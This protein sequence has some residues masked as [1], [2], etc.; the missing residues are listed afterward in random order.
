[1]FRSVGSSV[2]CW[3]VMHQNGWGWK[4]TSGRPLAQPCSS[5]ETQ[6]RVPWQ[7][8]KISKEE[9]WQSLWVTCASALLPSQH[10]SVFLSNGVSCAHF[11]HLFLVL[12]TTGKKKK[13]TNP[14][15]IL[16]AHI[17]QVFVEIN[18]IT[19]SLLFYKLSSSSSL[20]LAS[21]ERSSSPF[22][23]FIGPM[24][25]FLG[26]P[27][28]SCTGETWTE[29]S[30]PGVASSLLSRGE[31]SLPLTFFYAHY[32]AEVTIG[33]SCCKDVLVTPVHLAAHQDPQVWCARLL[34]IWIAPSTYWCV[35]FF[36]PN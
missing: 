25:L 16:F 13:T 15:S 12:G 31:D 35:E 7:F 21:W 6:S 2:V 10:L 3:A 5:R 17:L 36:L 34:S 27:C 28:N 26:C 20:I 22:I 1:M 9:T 32:A 33:C 18:E 24:W 23:I 14:G 29:L 19:L 11:C 8:L 4:G 30:T